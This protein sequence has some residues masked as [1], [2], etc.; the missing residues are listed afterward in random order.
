MTQRKAMRVLFAPI[1]Q[2]RDDE[3]DYMIDHFDRFPHV[4]RAVRDECLKR[5]DDATDDDRDT[6][7]FYGTNNAF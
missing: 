4:N 2:L 3:L 1:H 6:W 7:D 5:R